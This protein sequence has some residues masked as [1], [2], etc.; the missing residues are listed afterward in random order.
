MTEDEFLD[1]CERQWR[2]RAELVSLAAE[3]LDEIPTE[4]REEALAVLG[5]KFGRLWPGL[6]AERVL[7]RWPAI[8]VLTT[9]GVAADHYSKGTFWPK[10]ARVLDVR[11]SP[12][13]QTAWGDAFLR[14]LEK[15]NLPTFERDGDAGARYVG[16]ILLHSGMPTYCLADFF[17][18]ISWK[19][20]QVPGLT[21]AD[22]V[23]WATNKIE[24]SGFANV[25]MPV[26]R[27]IRYGDEFALDVADRSFELLDA[28]AAGA[29]EDDGLLPRRFW[30]AAQELHNKRGIERVADDGSHHA[31]GTV[32][33]PRLVID[34]F[35]QGL[36]L[37]LPPVGDAPDGKAVWVVTLDEDVQ[38]VATDSLWPG[39][40]EPAPQTDIAIG[41][42]VRAASIA[43]AGREHLQFPM[44]V[45][46]D[47]DPL[48][49]FGEDGE[50]IAPGLPMP[51]AKTWL[52][53]P[54]E[55]EKLEVT[56][57]LEIV[58]ESPLPPGWT[59]FCLIQADLSNATAVTV[60]GACRS[61]RK[62]ESA[63][64]ETEASV[65]GVRTASGLPVFAKIP[66]VVVP[67]TM[68]NATWDV[69]LHDSEGIVIS[70]RRTSGSE[71][72]NTLWDNISRPLVGTYS[73]KVRGPWGRGATRSLAIVEGLSVSFTPNWRRFIP[74]GLQ[75]CQAK[76]RVAVGVDIAR[77]QVDFGERDREHTL[78][79]TAHSRSCSLAV[80]PP[81]MTVAYQS[82]DSSI[83]PS[84]R[85]LALSCE[86][87]IES[88]GEL[89][90]DVGAAAEPV[91]HV[92]SRERSVQTIAP[93]LGRAGVYRFDLAQLVDTLREQPQVAL[94][95]SN[96]G[97]LVIATIRPRS[98]FK[99]I[100]LDGDALHF[101]DCVEAE[102]LTA[103]LFALRAPWRAPASVPIV[104]GKAQ[105]PDWLMDAGPI[106]VIARIEDPWIP[107]PPPD[108]SDVVRSTVLENDGWII[109]S[110]DEESAV[111][112]FLAGHRTIPAEVKNFARLW[113]ARALLQ[114]LC[115]GSRI[116]PA[117]KAIDEIIYS[118]PAAALSA[119]ANSEVPVDLIP[120]L[121]VRSGLAWANLADAHA[122]TAPPWT[123]RGALPAALLSAADS[124][125]SNEEIEAAEVICGDSVSGILDG[126]DPCASSGCLDESADLLDSN[127]ALREQ[128]VRTAGLI[129]QGILS[130]DSRVL[131]A[132]AF[133]EKRRHPR[134]EWL[135]K[136]AR[137]VLKESERLMRMIGDRATQ[138]AFTARLHRTRTGDWHVVPA[139]SMA[140]ALAAR[141]AS[142]GN[143][144][145]LRWVIREQRP[146]EDL[147]QVAPELVTI[148]L[149]IAE[150]TVGR[151]VEGKTGA[152]G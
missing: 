43:L 103:Y 99:G 123:V 81:H 53:F 44:M 19:R 11:N 61:V 14:N 34:P 135:V 31:G 55:P 20:S 74:G 38:R 107:L 124:L 5:K 47:Q 78:R 126:R 121:M 23:A 30:A 112:M 92:I 132:M 68:E 59:G 87:I 114:L 142:R 105:L 82:N 97:E 16:R 4:K 60:R 51:A 63:R 65:P 143:A 36:L 72:P 130:A 7:W 70:R 26:Q 40:T 151:R 144:D 10:L 106:R 71:D 146:W 91:L 147:A 95:L 129:P 119:L 3:T 86:D 111:S 49:A 120:T 104:A 84:V 115:L 6:A 85:P 66:R 35:G 110:D 88:A 73:I 98:L 22:F 113:T 54:G 128:W 56:G 58:A 116:E 100:T 145:A 18:I 77:S 13:F 137:S 140:F 45:I 122:N 83:S 27:F 80:S 108:W 2:A 57:S 76:V 139:L 28:V 48:L 75:P 118:R 12:Q 39:S 133:V 37:R 102:G 1:S 8:H 25:D 52:L 50:L 101:G 17:R 32:V 141:H 89:I 136:H 131:A 41:R 125:W 9:A 109:G 64:I 67:A 42:P 29:S 150:L 93:R 134:L 148:D 117:A 138:D 94:A 90:L 15:L 33:R 149:I 21:P 96:E 127:P 69:T 152:Q 24:G 46:D 62:F 79:A